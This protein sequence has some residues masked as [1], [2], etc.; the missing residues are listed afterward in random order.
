MERGSLTLARRASEG[1]RIG[2]DV[3]VEVRS[4]KGR[5]VKLVVRA[6]KSTRILRLEL[7]KRAA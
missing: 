1:I 4:V 5:V 7:E 3:E 6:P 2:A